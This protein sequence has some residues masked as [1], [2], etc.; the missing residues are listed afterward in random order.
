MRAGQRLS[1]APDGQVTREPSIGP[2]QRQPQPAGTGRPARV[3]PP[4]PPLIGRLTGDPAGPNDTTVAVASASICNGAHPAA[5]AT[6]RPPT[7]HTGPAPQAGRAGQPDPGAGRFTSRCAIDPRQERDAQ[8]RR[9]A[10]LCVLGDDHFKRADEVLLSALST[11]CRADE[12]ASGFGLVRSSPS[13]RCEP[14]G[15]SCS[16][17]DAVPGGSPRR[18]PGGLGCWQE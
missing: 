15:L 17:S 7:L 9:S 16:G 3:D 12:R 11:R 8:C 6:L 14:R 10:R 1:G 2:G 13:R 4:W 5:R 18:W